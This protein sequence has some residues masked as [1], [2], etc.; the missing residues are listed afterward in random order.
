MV[1]ARL[2]GGII[3]RRCTEQVRRPARKAGRALG[4]CRGR[5]RGEVEARCIEQLGRQLDMV[6][7]CRSVVAAKRACEQHRSEEGRCVRGTRRGGCGRTRFRT[8]SSMS[9]MYIYYMTRSA[10]GQYFKLCDWVCFCCRREQRKGLRP[11]RPPWSPVLVLLAAITAFPQV[12]PLRYTCLD[13][14]TLVVCFKLINIC[15][16]HICCHRYAEHECRCHAELDRVSERLY[17]VR[18]HHLGEFSL[19]ELVASLYTV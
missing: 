9:S 16:A 2:G 4:T 14:A 6:G 5:R 3:L 19:P 11:A 15:V 18:V 12:W 17:L 1:C 10:G 7:L 13:G 8:R